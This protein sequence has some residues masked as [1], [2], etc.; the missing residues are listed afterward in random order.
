MYKY[1]RRVSALKPLSAL[2]H[3]LTHPRTP[4][5]YFLVFQGVQVIAL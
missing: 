4:G 3:T 2:T 1:K 5:L